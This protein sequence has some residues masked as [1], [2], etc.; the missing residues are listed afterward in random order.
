MAAEELA[1][2]SGVTLSVDSADTFASKQEVARITQIQ[3]A[4]SYA[5]QSIDD[6]DAAAGE[7][8][9]QVLGGRSVT[10]TFG[11][12]LVP[13]DAGF[14]QVHT[15]KKAATYCY[16]ELVAVTTEAI[17]TTRTLQLGG[18]FSEVSE[19]YNKPAGTASMTFVA[20]EVLSDDIS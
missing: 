18:Y 16:L 15:F 3:V 11:T 5:V 1:Q 12:N 17:P 19:Q 13:S 6:F 9:D 4:D 7:I 2:F 10:V 14:Q 20:S 8:I